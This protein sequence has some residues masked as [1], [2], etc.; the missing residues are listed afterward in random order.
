MSLRRLGW[1]VAVS[2]AFAMVA[3]ATVDID[4]LTSAIREADWA[5]AAPGLLLFTTAKF[6]DSLRWRFLLREVGPPPQ[7]A[8]F[9]AFLVGNFV[10]NVLPLRVGDVAKVQLLANRYGASRAG[11]AASVF[12][13]E[14]ALD[15]VLFVLLLTPM[16]AFG[17][18][19]DVPRGAVWFVG[20]LAVL[21]FAVPTVLTRSPPE[22]WLVV[23]PR[24]W[25]QGA[26]RVV[27]ELQAGL[28]VLSQWR[29]AAAALALSAPAWLMEAGTFVLFG[30]AFGLELA[31]PTFV[32]AMV[33]A[34]LAVA[35]PL[36]LWNIGPY[37]TLVTTVLVAAGAEAS[38][39]L[40][41]AFAV[42]VTVNAWI[43]VT[44]IIA[45]WAM[46]ASPRDFIRFR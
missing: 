10:N 27:G 23:V 4:R 15:G 1:H 2:V 32:A 21:A 5:W 26:A 13:V 28:G 19:G 18:L 8:L 33:A 20:L 17:G 30:R 41:Y 39:A 7:R 35:V 12:A 25:Q 9:G 44:G 29:L 45:F 34:N 38:T 36:G 24:R 42:H 37:E 14:A 11:V 40:S 43:D 16:V 31:Y 6:V 3:L 46:G 22:R